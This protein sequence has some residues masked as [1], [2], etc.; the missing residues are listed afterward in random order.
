MGAALVPYPPSSKLVRRVADDHVELHVASEQ[1]GDPS[2]DVV[3]V[4]ER[5]G[6]GFESFASVE[7]L[8]ARAAVTCTCRPPT[9]ARCARTRCCRPSLVNDLAIECWPVGVLRAIDAPA[10]EQAGEM[11]DADAEH[12]LRQDVIDALLE[13]G[14]LVLPDLRSGGW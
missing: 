1:L 5:V 7:G 6:V 12:L 13:V 4:D 11:R 8:L 2:L 14:D 3:G 10:R 9:C